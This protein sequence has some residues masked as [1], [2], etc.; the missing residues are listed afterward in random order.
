VPPGGPRDET[1]PQLILQM[2]QSGMTNY[3]GDRI[4]IIFDEY[5]T[6]T[7]GEDKVIITPAMPTP[8]KYIAKGKKLIIKLPEYL[9]ENVTYSISLIDAVSDFTEGNKLP[10][11][12]CV[13]A[14]GEKIDSASLSGSVIDAFDLS[15]TA[16]IFVGLYKPSDSVNLKKKPLYVSKTNSQ[17]Q[18]RIDYVKEGSYILAA[19]E[20]KN[21]NFIFDQITE[22]ISMPSSIIDVKGSVILEEG[23]ILFKNESKI[24]VEGYNLLGN[25][26]LYFYFSEQVDDLGLDVNEYDSR[27]K[28]YFNTN[29][30]T[31]FYHWT[32][33]TLRALTF[34]F[35]LNGVSKDTIV[36]PLSK[37]KQNLSLSAVSSAALNQKIVVQS[38]KFIDQIYADGIAILDSN[39]MKLEYKLTQE[40]EY[41]A[42]KLLDKVIGSILI[43]IDSGSI[44][45][46][47]EDYN[48][49]HFVK[50]I[51]ITEAVEPSKLSLSFRLEQREDIYL[52]VLNKDK[53]MI[54]SQLVSN[55]DGLIVRDLR[56]GTYFIR[57]FQDSNQ[58]GKW[59][60]G[61]FESGVEP[62]PTLLF[63]KPIEIKEKWD[64]EISLSF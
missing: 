50:S 9:G 24:K 35:L 36:V 48:E 32:N 27:D 15:S 60:T 37:N 58:N 44:K 18:F 25:S 49:E 2:P 5:I 8:P 47:D 3:S 28:A 1:A 43:S 29:N 38:P 39:N 55:N 53:V 40:N 20:D 57:V 14:T 46:Y 34:N 63:S 21:F 17:G 30:D 45:Y 12:R 33:D 4:E 7:G 11:L 26:K 59:T 64:K 10:L 6:F 41:L 42:F 56:P 23:L 16:N 61:S 19:I 13:F 31:L 54:S 22:R 51:T 52:Q 62:E